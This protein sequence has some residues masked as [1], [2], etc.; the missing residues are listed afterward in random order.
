MPDIFPV[1]PAK[2]QPRPPI[3]RSLH[4]E[5]IEQ[6]IPDWLINATQTRRDAFRAG[7]LESPSWYRQASTAQRQA[8]HTQAVASF[9]AQTRLDKAMASLQ[10][11][12]HFAEPLL[13]KA[14]K[15]QFNVTLDVN[16][17]L[18]QLRQPV[19]VGILGIDVA[20][21]DVL[22]L[23]LLQAALHNFE[24]SECKD[25]AFHESSGFIEQDP[26]TG[27]FNPVSTSLTVAQFTQLC[28]TLDIGAQYQL[29]LKNYLQPKDAVAEHVL[30]EKFITAQ[31][32]ALRA[33]A[34]IALLKKDIQPEDYRMILSVVAGEQFPT[35][36]GKPVWFRDLSLM[37]HRMT[38]CVL[39]MISEKYRYTDEWILY[40]PHDPQS[41]LKRYTGASM[42]SAF[43]QRFTRRDAAATDD[44]NPTPYQRFFSRFVAY[45]DLPDYFSQLT[46]DVPDPSFKH[47]A[48]AYVPLLNEVAKGFNP[49][50]LFTGLRKLPPLPQAS[51]K[52]NPDPYLAPRELTREGHGLW[53]ENVD[54]WTYLFDQHRAKIIADARA[55]AVPTADADAKA[56]SEKF[57][58]LLNIGMLLFTAVTMFV[59]VLG[60][61]M[62]VVMAGQLLYETFEGALEWS[63]GDRR[64]AKAHLLDVAENL[65]LLAVT[66]GAGKA[67][68]KLAGVKAEPV[69]ENL[70]AVTLPNDQTR[71]WK[72]DLSGY[73][74]SVSLTGN[75][76][77]LGQY[78][79]N[80]KTFIRLDGKVYE[81]TWDPSLK[82]WRLRHPTDADA[83]QPLLTHNHAGAWRHTLERPLDWDRLT[84][85]RRMGPVTQAFT[86][87][88][89]LRI[90]DVS[91]V[92]DNTLRK[93]HVDNA[94]PP[95]ALTDAMRLFDADQ[96]VD[97]V[98]EQLEGA[99]PINGRYLYSLPLV[100]QM[101]RWPVGRVLEVFEGDQLSGPSI[102]YGSELRI[103]TGQRKAALR[104]TR[105]DV[106]GGQLTQRIIEQLDEAEITR[107]LGAEPARVPA[108]R[109]QEF[110]KQL[111]HFART[112]QPAIF[113]SLYTGTERQSPWVAKLQ[114]ECP[115][116]SVPAAQTVLADADGAEH[117]R[118]Q[119]TGK[120][121]L[122]LLE[123]ARWYAQQGRLGQAYAGLHL[124]NMASADSRRLALS[125]L[126]ELP[127]WT[128]GLR[129][130]VR[131]GTFSG[132]QLD[133]IGPQDAA[134]RKV[135]VKQG[136]G[137][138][139]FDEQGESLHSVAPGGKNFYAALMQALPDETRRALGVPEVN[140][141]AQL[142]RLIIDEAIAHPDRAAQVI[143]ER[144]RVRAGFKPPQRISDTLI[145]YPASGRRPGEGLDLDARVKAVY[146]QLTDDQ[147]SGFLLRQM[148]DGKSE[149]DIVNLLNTRI[150][151][152]QALEATLDQWVAEGPPARRGMAEE[153]YGR[154][155]IVR[156]LKNSWQMAPLADLPQYARLDLHFFEPL[157]ALE[158]DFSHIRQLR[159][160]DNGLGDSN[161][162]A[163]LATFPKV[164]RLQISITNGRVRRMPD[165]LQR[166]SQL[167]ELA[168]SLRRF[169]LHR[170]I[171]TFIDQLGSADPAVY[172]KAE[173]DLQ[174]Q[175]MQQGGLFGSAPPMQILDTAGEVLWDDPA[176]PAT[177]R[178]RVVI[179]AEQRARGETLKQVLHNLQGTDPALK[180][181][182]GKPSDS[183][184]QRAAELR[185][186]LAQ[187]AQSLKSAL[188][189]ERYRAQTRSD[190]ADVQRVLHYF[191]GLPGDIARMLLDRLS[192]P[193]LAA[194]RSGKRLPQP[195]DDQARW[196][197]QQTRA[198]RAYEGLFHD[199]LATLDSQ[200][201][202]LRTLVTLPGW[203]RGT[204]VE[205]RQYSA[206]GE[207][208]DAIGSPDTGTSRSVVLNASGE[209][210]D[211]PDLYSALWRQL[212]PTERQALGF[213]DASELK[214]AI[215]R[216]P[217]PR[218][219]LL[220]VLQEH[221][222]RKPAY[223][224]SMRLLSGGRGL[225]QWVA[226]AANT[227]RTPQA[228]ARKLFKGF[229]DRDVDAFIESLGADV[230][231]GLARL[232]TEYAT[233]RHDLNRW[234]QSYALSAGSALDVAHASE[235]AV[236]IRR[237]WRRQSY[238]LSLVLAPSISLPTLA[239]DFSHI[240]EL[241]LNR[242]T[243]SASADSF[244]KGFTGLK[245]LTVHSTGLAQ[246][247][248]AIGAM[249]QLDFLRLASNGLRLNAQSAAAL[250]SLDTLTYLDL[251]NNPLGVVPDFSAMTR[252]EYLFLHNTGLD[253]WPTGIADHRQLKRLDLRDNQLREVPADRLEPAPEQL[254]QTVRVNGVIAMAGNPFPAEVGEQVDNYWQRLSQQHP[255]W[256]DSGITD[257]FSVDSPMISQV[258]H[259]HPNMTYMRA[260]EMIWSLGDGAGARLTQL[261]QE[262]DRLHE[263]LN[264]WVFSGGGARQRY[265][266]QDQVRGNALNRNSRYEAKARILSCWLRETP[267]QHANDGTPFGLELDLSGLD[268]PSL[269]DLEADFSHVGSLKLNNLNLSASPEGFLATFRGLRWLQM[270]NNQLRE[271]PPALEQMHR[272][273]KLWLDDNQIR[274][275]E[276]TAQIL[277]SRTTLRILWLDGNPLGV[278]PDFSALTDL[279]GLSMI[280]TGLTEWPAGLG[281][282]PL[283][284]VIDLDD[285]QLT[286]L[287]Q[288]LIAPTP[289]QLEQ[290]RRISRITSVRDNPFSEATLQQVRDY[291]GQVEEQ[292]P[293][294]L[295]ETA[296]N[297]A[298]PVRILFDAGPFERWTAGLDRGQRI[299]RKGQWQSLQAQPGAGG[300]F[301]MLAD[302]PNAGAEHADLQQRVWA[303]IDSITQHNAESE[304]L[305]ERMFEWAGRAACC[306]RAALSFSNVEV[307]AMVDNAR[308]NASDQTQAAS[309]I[310]L[311]RRLFRLDE[312]EK[313][314]Q[315]DIAT[316]TAAI[317][318]NPGLSAAQKQRQIQMLEEVE[319][320]LAYRVGLKAPQR[321]DLPGQPSR[322][323]FT[324]LGHVSQTM[325]NAAQAKVLALNNSPQ[326]I[327]ALLSREFWQDFVTGKYRARFD[328]LSKPYHEKLAA[329][330]EQVGTPALST[331]EFETQARD[332]QAQLAVE[333]AALIDTLTRQEL[334][335]HPLG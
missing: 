76:N 275:S 305:R 139:A 40:I 112:R 242:V 165:A 69:I 314:A 194:L 110:A 332:I 98:L 134:S 72:A 24:A 143:A 20:S 238:K 6:A 89:L 209:Y 291:A 189:E 304:A 17:T 326:E 53:A 117:A 182:P 18:L 79:L 302:L 64:A 94:L 306:D 93:M 330:H 115:G 1:T 279:R 61:L 226:S 99:R 19:E 175:L 154:R 42:A 254:E 202:A 50:S 103:A 293:N 180:E 324:S 55:H 255:E 268:L 229:S 281:E 201:L 296:L 181:I 132:P 100:T 312:V 199:T 282:Q 329:L 74:H 243:W 295:V 158:A 285:N 287:P 155:R 190:D 116:L 63:E 136:P 197:E 311:S 283:L 217:L 178:R 118:M 239:A 249:R 235:A 244:L 25:G 77:P 204:R 223:D 184:D 167:T 35:V 278:Y 43:K 309:L 104:I 198:S 163:L 227:L 265:I 269:P 59:P 96:G 129:L 319:I 87:E 95:P 208:L 80:G 37:K 251:S 150:R 247:P 101:P 234:V 224:A 33:A 207:V 245:R 325:L 161:V 140:Q 29:Y 75:A 164:E 225:R 219:P 170:Q 191:P 267:V 70:D 34:E 12:D 169:R 3:S 113:D 91:G 192:D 286:R 196:A 257:G 148:V 200:R 51:R 205:L 333:E 252:L 237:C 13:V 307:M 31:Q 193:E 56:R 90:A 145:G 38:G 71:L 261:V 73:E 153:I 108:T 220:T 289:E 334:V 187:R 236:E 335:E 183:L 218:G 85:L 211:L 230:R 4:G 188:V 301:D 107:L 124:E 327:Q 172:A 8:L 109:P 173:L 292:S 128:P 214:H 86:D 120:I 231:G 60:E 16:K 280:D 14:L 303:V 315:D 264:A 331:P 216:A 138:Q 36:G 179:S 41:P 185:Q 310:K 157:P 232:E 119:D 47:K 57:A 39:F 122:R 45:A 52:A 66:A 58:R 290:S 260:R 49:F 221:P 83:Y 298:A 141:H 160:G 206:G 54:L 67:F 15:D 23:P 121:P 186:Y 149:R 7:T 114:R 82:R 276:Q 323:L 313:I 263:Q 156:T 22:K 258:R 317:N 308:A 32:A 111:A 246:L 84:L 210:D 131:E 262:F 146:T 250:A 171:S 68:A 105:A 259:I 11:V 162:E 272:L 322:T 97:Q 88:Q 300:F 195:L 28:R 297:R 316:R 215:V 10:D 248:E 159:V 26:A 328:A 274:L 144:S 253:Q 46:E 102:K 147:V 2:A 241:S 125:S 177:A 5:F 166:L 299:S 151:E 152:W 284:E 130:E 81:T 135:L 294:T 21:Y 213:R 222:L 233:L 142:Q 62:L 9:A 168:D 270:K 30:R 126:A 48:A 27:A 65:A 273:T 137:Y 203:V 277:A 266:R 288:T 256:L 106:L 127:G 240:Q 44:D 228:R 133:A 321:L 174:M 176:P 123:Q 320:R 271:L 318:D 92:D 78:E 212:T